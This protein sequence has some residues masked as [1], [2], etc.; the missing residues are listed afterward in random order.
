MYTRLATL[1]LVPQGKISITPRPRGGEWLA[2]E[3]AGWRTAGVD[4]L[5][6]LLSP[7]EVWD[8]GLSDEAAIC[9][10]S[11]IEFRAM[12][13]VDRSTPPYDTQTIGLITGL[14]ADIRAGRHIAIH[15]RLGIGRSGLI[16]ASTLVTLGV[17]VEQAFA[18][19]SEARG[20]TVPD[21]Q[22]QYDWVVEYDRRLHP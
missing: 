19:L 12:P 18:R 9:T 3:I 13:I 7:G 4:V 21:T 15:C 14:A 6:C 20:L 2:N 10:A 16:A 11:S 22:A 1:A 5:V 8:L 17:P